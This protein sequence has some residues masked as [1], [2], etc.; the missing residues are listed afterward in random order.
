MILNK[1]AYENPSKDSWYGD[2]KD[3]LDKYDIEALESAGIVEAW[4]IY[5]QGSYD[6]DGLLV[7]KSEKGLYVLKSLSHCSCNGP[8]DGVDKPSLTLEELKN[9]NI[10]SSDDKCMFDAIINSLTNETHV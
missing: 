5:A 1:V 8:C 6:G 3:S 4:Y 9:K 2:Y 10:I 7:G